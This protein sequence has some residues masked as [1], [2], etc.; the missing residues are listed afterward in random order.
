MCCLVAFA[1]TALQDRFSHAHC[2]TAATP[3]PASSHTVIATYRQELHDTYFKN[4][5]YARHCH[6]KRIFRQKAVER[7]V[8]EF[9]GTADK[10]EQKKVIVAFGD[11]SFASWSRRSRSWKGGFSTM[12]VKALKERARVVMVNEYLTS[13]K[14][15]KCFAQLSQHGTV[16]AWRTKR[17]K[18]G[19][20]L[21]VWNRDVNAAINMLNILFHA[22]LFGGRHPAY[23]RGKKKD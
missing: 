23:R 16:N 18:N 10:R 4:R 6:E 21:R 22:K 13:Q 11:A 8:A 7:V 15:S 5:W 3:R 9:L 1:A 20:C 17:C 12:W 2:G 19:P 14:C